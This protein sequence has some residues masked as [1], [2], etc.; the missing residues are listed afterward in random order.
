MRTVQDRLGLSRWTVAN[1]IDRGYCELSFCQ[2]A[3]IAFVCLNSPGF[4]G[5][6]RNDCP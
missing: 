2:A 3:S 5:Q 4:Y 1:W 6:G